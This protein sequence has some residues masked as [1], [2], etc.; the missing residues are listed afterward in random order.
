MG[1]EVEE[2]IEVGCLLG[3]HANNSQTPALATMPNPILW[4][5]HK[6]QTK[7]SARHV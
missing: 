2:I 5:L 1:R 7:L 3:S 6:S 4:V